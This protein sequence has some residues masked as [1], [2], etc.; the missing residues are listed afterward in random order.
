MTLGEEVEFAP[1]NPTSPAE[2]LYET[3]PES[4]D[5]YDGKQIIINSDR[6]IF[7]AKNKEV[8]CF[9]KG[10]TYFNSTANF[11]IDTDKDFLMNNLGQ[12][13]MTCEGNY[14]I[15]SQARLRIDGVDEINF[16]DEKGELI[17]KGETL[18]EVLNDLIDAIK[19]SISPSGA[20]AGPFPVSLVNPSY[21]DAVSSKLNSFLSEKVTTV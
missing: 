11:V 10:D 12:V 16:G 5:I 14:Y 2:S 6:L 3:L 19:K 18:I 8:L 4:P 1:G 21:L 7:N 20:I 9:S 13:S 15:Q 17:V